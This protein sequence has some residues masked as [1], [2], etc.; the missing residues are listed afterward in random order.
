MTIK[1]IFTDA[2]LKKKWPI[3]DLLFSSYPAQA[4]EELRAFVTE[5]CIDSVEN[6]VKNEGLPV[7]M[8]LLSNVTS[9]KV[10][11][12]MA[13]GG[14]QAGLNLLHIATLAGDVE[15]IDSLLR[16]GL[17]IDRPASGHSGTALM[18][19]ANLGDIKLMTHLRDKGA[20]ISAMSKWCGSVLAAAAGD[21]H[22]D[23]ATLV[24]TWAREQA[25]GSRLRRTAFLDYLS[26]E[27]EDGHTAFTLA[28]ARGALDVV[29][30]MLED[31]RFSD[32]A[33]RHRHLYK[34]GLNK[35]AQ[36]VAFEAGHYDIVRY[37]LDH[38]TLSTLKGSHQQIS[39]TLFSTQRGRVAEAFVRNTV[40]GASKDNS[41]VHGKGVAEQFCLML[42]SHLNDSD[43]CRWVI[44]KNL[45]KLRRG[46]LTGRNERLLRAQLED[47]KAFSAQESRDL[48]KLTSSLMTTGVERKINNIFENREQR[49]RIIDRILPY[50]KV[51]TT[52]HFLSAQGKEVMLG[53]LLRRAIV[54]S[55]QESGIIFDGG[56]AASGVHLEVKN[57]AE[58]KMTPQ[59]RSMKRYVRYAGGQFVI[60]TGTKTQLDSTLG[61]YETRGNACYIQIHRWAFLGPK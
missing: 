44:E 5:Y 58:L 15:A 43:F 27:R 31:P 47:L 11:L 38:E 4:N 37:L 8:E 9:R 22:V 53:W 61:K 25:D 36:D 50:E 23:A 42:D 13:I 41:V 6:L 54:I 26:L 49:R 32:S 1:E 20:N 48:Q 40:Y 24:L 52:T 55:S 7:V 29:K 19:A 45:S 51:I 56:K 46:M 28:C 3:L 30:L 12:G 10:D 39:E 35:S 33:A 57:T 16:A 17:D 18:L 21:N 14:E 34:N 59:L 2:A 60:A